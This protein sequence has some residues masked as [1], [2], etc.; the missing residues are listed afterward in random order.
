VVAV[1]CSVGGPG[2][3]H[4]IL[5]ALPA[6]FAAPLLV[7]QHLAEGFIDGLATWLDGA[8]RLTVKVARQGEK[9]IPGRVYL[10]PHDRHLTVHGERIALSDAPPREGFRP[11]ASVLFEGV[12]D[13]FGAR[14]IGVILTGLGSD[15]VA[16]LR[17]LRSAGGHVLAQDERTSAAFGMPGAAIEAGVCDA[18][19]PVDR[20]AAH[21]QERLR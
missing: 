11:A 19:L 20:I 17:A 13:A 18:V 15:G 5:S 2:A 6:D 4:E 1:G 7:A 12:A 9:L 16:G 14:A 21:L 8:S 3:L 10:A